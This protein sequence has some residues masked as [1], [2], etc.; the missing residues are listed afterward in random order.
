MSD[1]TSSA[2]RVIPPGQPG[3]IG[4]KRTLAEEPGGEAMAMREAR[5]GTDADVEGEDEATAA[6]T[7]ETTRHLN[8]AT[9]TSGANP[10]APVG[11][12]KKR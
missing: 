11:S 5:Y 6:D 2:G 4:I 10:Y 8:D 1:K 3:D 9:I 12:E 7:P